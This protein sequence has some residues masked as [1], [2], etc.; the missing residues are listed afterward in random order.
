M[1]MI[2]WGTGCHR[3]P[4]GTRV[5][6]VRGVAVAMV[7]DGVVGIG[8]VLQVGITEVLWANRTVAEVL[9][10]VGIIVEAI[11]EV[12][13]VVEVL[14]E[15]GITE[16]LREVGI[17]VAVL[18]VVRITEMVIMVAGITEEALPEVGIIEE[19]LLEV[20]IIKEVLMEDGIIEEVPMV[21]RITEVDP[22]VV[23][24][25]EGPGTIEAV[26]AVGTVVGV[27]VGEV[28]ELVGGRKR[29]PLQEGVGTTG[30]EEDGLQVG[31]ALGGM[32]GDPE[33]VGEVRDGRLVVGEGGGMVEVGDGI[34][35]AEEAG[36][37]TEGMLQGGTTADEVAEA[38]GAARV[39]GTGEETHLHQEEEAGEIEGELQVLV[40]SLLSFPNAGICARARVCVH[41]CACVAFA[42]FTKPGIRITPLNVTPLS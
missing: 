30:V 40:L 2:T 28:L 10:E 31:V 17:V 39:A 37:M 7:M 42:V 29:V 18:L 4:G 8:E 32:I 38:I 11:P 34:A 9:L 25:V 33:V 13:I 24:T 41:A 36:V 5:L 19:V 12:G 26:Q 3:D 15:L 27:P 14:M 22:M 16:V 1:D 21:V 20:G 35:V 23:G 6:E